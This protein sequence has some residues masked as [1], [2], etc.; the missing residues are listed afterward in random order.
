MPV[1]SI[2]SLP[3]QTKKNI[4]GILKKINAAA[5]GSIGVESRHIW[6]YWEFLSPNHYAVGDSTS[7]FTQ[8][9]SHSPI[10]EVISFEGKPGDSVEA[11]LTSI[12]ETISGE[13]GIDIGSIFITYREVHSGE[14]FDGG[15]IVR[16]K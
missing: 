13:T 9:Q 10:V 3:F 2:K 16:K 8:A 11:L 12:A 6:S 5:A 7:E 15:E 4:S 14:V 1:I